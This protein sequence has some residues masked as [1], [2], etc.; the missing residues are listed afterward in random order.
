MLLHGT[1]PWV[2]NHL[3]QMMHGLTCHVSTCHPHWMMH[4]LTCPVSTCHCHRVTH[5][6]T[7]YV[8]TCHGLTC[9]VRTCHPCWVMRGLTC[10]VRT[11]HPH[12]NKARP[13][14]PCHYATPFTLAQN[15]TLPP[16][17]LVHFIP[18]TKLN[19]AFRQALPQ[20]VFTINSVDDVIQ[21]PVSHHVLSSFNSK[22]K[23]TRH[24]HLT[25]QLGF[26]SLSLKWNR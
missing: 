26:H 25:S 4:G 20:L 13:N 3:H 21:S 16:I 23:P 9:Q 19:F 7:R 22:V 2:A 12:K 1:L 10:H 6:L 11:C 24:K 17:L 14:V 8:R 5:N 15:C 18:F